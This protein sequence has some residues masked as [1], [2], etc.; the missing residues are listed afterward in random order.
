MCTE[1]LPP[2][3]YPIAVKYIYH[4]HK[5]FVAANCIARNLQ[6]HVK[7][8]SNIATPQTQTSRKNIEE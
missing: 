8:S 2:G 3:G 5:K 4:H 6:W 1:Q 7:T